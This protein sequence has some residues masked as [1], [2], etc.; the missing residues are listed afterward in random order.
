M[1]RVS[2]I[3]Q[4]K[5][6]SCYQTGWKWIMK[7][8]DSLKM[9]KFRVIFFSPTYNMQNTCFMSFPPL[10]CT[11]RFVMTLFAWLIKILKRQLSCW[12]KLSLL[13]SLMCV[14]SFFFVIPLLL[15]TDYNQCKKNEYSL[16]S[17]NPIVGS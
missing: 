1:P 4:Y 13:G 9:H 12:R 14:F 5:I 2:V 17:I 8:S 7:S 6:S 11:K 3:D 15:L 10:F 16:T